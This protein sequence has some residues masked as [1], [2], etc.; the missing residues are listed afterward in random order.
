MSKRM[1]P[2]DFENFLNGSR[3]KI[4]NI[5]KELD[6]I[7]TQ[8]VSAHQVNQTMHDATLSDLC[9]RAAHDLSV[10]PADIR[11]M[12]DED[13]PS[14]RE[15]LEKRR[16]EL[17]SQIVP[18]AQDIAD[19]LVA[20]AQRMTADTRELNQGLNAQEERLKTNL[21]K[22]QTEL[23]GLN[24]E[25]ARR[26]GCLA[27]FVN[28][29]KLTDLDRKRQR[30]LGRMEENGKELKKVREEW[31]EAKTTYATEEANLQESWQKA[32]VNAAQAREELDQLSDDAKLSRLALQR[33]IFYVF[34]NWKTPM[35]SDGNPLM[36]EI[37][38]MV[39]FNVQQ[40]AYEEGLGKVAGLIA[41]L[42]GLR[43]GLESFVRSV[44]AVIH[45]QQ[46]HSAYLQ[47]VSVDVDDGVLQF[48][49]Q[50]DGLRAQVKDEKAIGQ[51]PAEF[52]AL[53][54]AAIKGPLAEANIKSMFD[55]LG[56]SLDA[57]THGWRG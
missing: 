46:R 27:S 41:L 12:I 52:S 11:H 5:A 20:R 35:S 14:E 13:V 34:D 53:F 9:A 50:W 56:N 55:S 16:Q 44:E 49:K 57:A 33:A 28:F 29:F 31:A 38:Q 8:F 51:H 10:F 18:K 43:S 40:D 24:D 21:A 37:N 36:D 54:D 45:E 7:Q 47:S 6:E 26:S 32:A 30:L 1:S 48:H 3:A 23:K 25:I 2:Q 22:M 42:N 4:D 17:L 39:H 15:K 19:D